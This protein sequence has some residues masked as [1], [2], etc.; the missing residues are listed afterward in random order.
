MANPIKTE[1]GTTNQAYVVTALNSLADGSIAVL[2]ELNIE[3]LL[4]LDIK[5][6]LEITT[7]TSV[8][9]D[10][11]IRIFA[12][13]SV[14]EGTTYPDSANYEHTLIGIM[15]A[16]ADSTEFRKDILSLVRAY[17]GKMP[18]RIKILVK[19]ETGAALHASAHEGTYQGVQEQVV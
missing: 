3:A 4:H 6:M 12:I 9:S 19:N 10:G 11:V 15:N 1:F 2:P 5:L 13:S 17:G 7:G 14:D 8:D 18:P 16:N